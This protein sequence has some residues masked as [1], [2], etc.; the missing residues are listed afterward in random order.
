MNKPESMDEFFD[1]VAESYDE[2]MKQ[3]IE[4]FEEFYSCI[5]TC[6]TET[7]KA[8]NV[9]DIGCGTGLEFEAIF[10]KAPRAM[11]TGID[12]SGEMLN[13]L[14]DKYKKRLGQIALIQKSYLAVP[15]GKDV[16]DYVISVM[17]LHHLL[18]EQKRSQ[19]QKIKESLKPG[20]KYVEGDYIVTLEQEKQ[21]LEK[22]REKRRSDANIGD[23]THHIDIPF[24]LNTQRRLLAEAGFSSMEVLW[25][26][27]KA[28]VYVAIV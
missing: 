3:N 2:H 11:I 22:Y 26:G 15:F 21:F 19:Y 24:S 17:T 10:E 13:I 20:G 27:E 16:Y 28:A 5:S 18:P 7:E 4:S 1:K 25:Q 12:V 8:I 9:L 23:G 14:R 6:I